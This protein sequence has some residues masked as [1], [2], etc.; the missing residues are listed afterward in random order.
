MQPVTYAARPSA[1]PILVL[2]AL[3]ATQTGLLAAYLSGT[4][5]APTALAVHAAVLVVFTCTKGAFADDLTPYFLTLLLT[6]C[7]GPLGA[8]SV[9][10]LTLLLARTRVS[11]HDLEDWYR[12]I[13]GVREVNPAVVLYD[14]IIDGRARRPGR[15]AIEHFPSVLDGPLATQQALLGL[16]GLSYHPDYRA[17]LGQALRSA[18]PSIRVHAA[19]VSVK[20]RT[21]ARTEFQMLTE[22]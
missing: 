16:I 9:L 22:L 19:A 2:L 8:G 13:S 21:R 12:Q 4:L 20:L 6:G 15:C 11:H 10:A 18:E 1:L 7:A 3:F 17:L 14:K 5:A